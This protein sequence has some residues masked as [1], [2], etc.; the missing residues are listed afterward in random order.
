MAKRVNTRRIRAN[1]T[2]TVIEA[3]Q[4]CTVT[5]WTVRNWIKKG[6]PVIDAQRPYLIIGDALKAYLSDRR[7]QARCTLK[8]G[9]LYC[10]CCRHP[11]RPLGGGVEVVTYGRRFA[12]RATCSHCETLCSRFVSVA[13][14]SDFAKITTLPKLTD[15]TAKGTAKLLLKSIDGG[16]HS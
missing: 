14:I 13:Q 16:R 12:V 6:L 4:A 5:P 1:R 10:T 8:A 7:A 3:A 2:Y 11:T 15:V 9:E